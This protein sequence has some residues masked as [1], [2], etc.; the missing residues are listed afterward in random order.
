MKD[1]IQDIRRSYFQIIIY[2]LGLYDSDMAKIVVQR[3]SACKDCPLNDN[4]WCSKKKQVSIIDYPHK[5]IFNKTK[6]LVITGCG[7]WLFA[8]KFSITKS[9]CPL[10]R[11]KKFRTYG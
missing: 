6:T 9:P 7:C 8:K 4:G 2:W 1:I 10:N 5:N 11:W 3:K